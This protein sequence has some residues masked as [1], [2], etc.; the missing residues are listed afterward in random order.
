[1]T[2]EL[3]QELPDVV[4]IDANGYWWRYWEDDQLNWS[5]IP[6]NSDN[7]PIPTPIKFYKLVE[8]Q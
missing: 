5:M 8:I 1:M 6:T 7:S 4:A 2:D 3:R